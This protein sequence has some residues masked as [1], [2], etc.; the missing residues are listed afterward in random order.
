M[1]L[2]ESD[3][4]EKYVGGL[5]D[6]IQGS[7]MASKPKTMQDAIEF[8]TE[9]MD[10]KI[11]TFAD[12]PTLHGLGRRKCTEDLNPCALNATTIMM[13]CVLPSATTVRSL[14]IWL[15]IVEGNYKK[16]CP[17]MKNNNCGN[18]AGNG[19]ATTRAYAVGNAR[20]NTDSNVVTGMFHLNNCYASILFDTVANKSFVSFAFCSLIDIISTTLDHDYDVELVDRKIIGVNTI[21]RDSTLN[22]L[23][24]PFNID[25][26]PTE[27]GSF[28]VIIGMD[29]LSMYHAVIVCDEKIVCIPF[30][31]EILI[32]CGDGSNNG[33]ESRLNIISCTKTQKYFL[34]GC[35]VVL[36]HVTTKKAED[37]SKEKHLKTYQ[38][39][40]TL[41]KYFSRTCRLT[42][43]NRY[44]LPRIDDLFDQLQ[45]SSV[46][47][48]IDLRSGY[49]QLRVREEDILITAFR[50]H[51]GHY[52]FQ[53]MPF[54]LTNAPAVF[55][56]L[57]NQVCKPC[58]DKF[59]IVFIDDILIYSK[60][61][62]E[63]KEPL[64][65]I[66]EL[67]K[68][69]EF[70]GIHVDP[71][72][73]KSIKDWAASNAMEI[74]LF[75]GLVGYYQRFIKGFSKITKSMTKLNQ[76][77]NEKVLA[78]ASRQLKIHE[79]NY[80][81]HDMELGAVVFALTIWRHYLYETKCIVFADHKSL[82]RILDQKELNMRQRR[83]L[84]LL[85]DYDCEIC[86]HPG[87][88]NQ[89]LEAHIEA[90]KPKNLE[91]QDVGG[92]LVKTS[93]ES[94]NP[95][96]EK[97][98]PRADRTLCLNNRSWLP[99]QAARVRQKSYADVR[100]KPLEFQAGDKVMLK[101]HF[102]E[103]PVEIIDREVKW[104]K[105]SRIQII[106]VRWNS[107]RGPE[108]TW[109]REDQFNK[110]YPHLFTNHASSSNATS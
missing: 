76:K 107:R 29:W 33:H 96:K 104:L 9:L 79:K 51:Y 100:R 102:V 103:E 52:E 73:V 89:I 108:F 91:A 93:R 86:Y 35:D 74:H 34:K 56:D 13:G 54:G 69:E 40:E 81:T 28:N 48:K 75:L 12:R 98:E 16:D 72:K 62:Q 3:E 31:K 42:V 101:L 7:V 43:K 106:K 15:V 1:F 26:M 5:P 49:H 90:R 87:K 23:N 18:P 68:K 60:S 110:K 41:L 17:K 80:T 8:E 44:P 19:G 70:K 65:I 83:W 25:L 66:L 67:L 82:Q 47:S 61:K 63:H 11:H 64:K 94:E 77:K 78:Y 84:E 10:Q 32:V 105:Q 39:F 45:G 38:L 6:M 4:V 53:V 71:S 22:F 85:I 20:K 59:V 55:M 57:M 92:M 58:L 14:A 36:A 27:I 37:N 24:H 30:A 109:E 46:Y 50:T 2:E 97:L 99:I 88:A 95:R 21:I